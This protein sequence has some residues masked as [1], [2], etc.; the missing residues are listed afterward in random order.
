M[1]YF[2]RKVKGPIVLE[3]K[4]RQPKKKPQQMPGQIAKHFL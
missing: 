1:V 2:L 4:K 3:H